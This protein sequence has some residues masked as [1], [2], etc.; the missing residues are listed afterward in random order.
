MTSLAPIIPA[1]RRD[2]FN[3]PAFLFELKLEGFR[4]L[5]DTIAGRMLSKNANRLRRIRA[6]ARHLADWIRVRR[7]VS[8]EKV[9]RDIMNRLVIAVL[10]ASLLSPALAQTPSVPPQDGELREGVVTR[11]ADLCIQSSKTQY[12]LPGDQFEQGCRCF[13]RA[14]AD[15]MNSQDYEALSL[16]KFTES[17]GKKREQ[18][19]ASCSQQTR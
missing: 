2:T 1:I 8:L 9:R 10:A 7:R 19:L 18:A 4:G 16:G 11:L 6:A 17:I 12:G 5:A 3:D 14:M 13:A 15:A